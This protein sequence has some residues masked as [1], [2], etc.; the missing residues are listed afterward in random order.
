MRHKKPTPAP[1]PGGGPQPAPKPPMPGPAPR[2]APAKPGSQPECRNGGRW[3]GYRIMVCGPPHAARIS[4]VHLRSATQVRSKPS[5][6][7]ANAGSPTGL[8]T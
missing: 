2:P 8:P 1:Q 7:T 5:S 6:S 3:G 4:R